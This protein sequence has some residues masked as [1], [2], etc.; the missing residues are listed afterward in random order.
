[1]VLTNKFSAAQH[2]VQMTTQRTAIMLMKERLEE[3]AEEV[4]LICIH[5][6]IVSYS[7][8]HALSSMYVIRSFG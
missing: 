3:T 6:K 5:G 1:M 2:V 8:Y 4:R 7:T